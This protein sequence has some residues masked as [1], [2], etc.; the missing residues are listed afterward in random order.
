MKT[1]TVTIRSVKVKIPDSMRL[2][3]D[4][5]ELVKRLREGDDLVNYHFG[6][7]KDKFELQSAW[8]FVKKVDPWLVKSL[9]EKTVIKIRTPGDRVTDYMLT[10]K[11]EL[12]KIVIR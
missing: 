1:R 6:V 10:P 3:K 8:G 2:V 5:A 7:D 12:S 9:V 11:G 4:Q